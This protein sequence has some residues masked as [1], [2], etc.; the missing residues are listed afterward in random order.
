MGIVLW[1]TVMSLDGFIA[2]A[3]DAMEWVFRYPEPIPEVDEVIRSTG[4]LLVGRRSYEVG[5]REAERDPDSPAARPFGGAW[6]GPQF[7]LTHQPPASSADP[8]ITFVS[9]NIGAAV[10][11]ALAAAAGKS[12]VVIG[13]NVAGQCLEAGRVDEILIHLAPILLGD[14][15]PLFRHPGG[16][17]FPLEPISVTRAGQVTNLRFRAPRISPLAGRSRTQPG[18]NAGS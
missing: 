2:G 9:G 10:D 11:R 13:A 14:G 17:T 3:G 7:V 4:A 12:V 5:R 1:H 16:D 15:I 8:S 18:S 6:S